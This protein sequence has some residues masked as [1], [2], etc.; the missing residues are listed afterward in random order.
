MDLTH[1]RITDID[2]CQKHLQDTSETLNWD[3]CEGKFWESEKHFPF[4]STLTFQNVDSHHT[5]DMLLRG[6]SSFGATTTAWKVSVFGVFLVCIFPH[7]DWIRRDVFWSVFS[8]NA[9]KYGPEK[10]RIRTLF[11]HCTK[12]LFRDGQKLWDLYIKSRESNR[13]FSL[14]PTIASTNMCWIKVNTLKLQRPSLLL[15]T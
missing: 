5:A 13:K 15:Q 6:T 7:S 14:W 12:L 9:G 1:N 4:F 10:L 2:F 3:D 8:P 11:T